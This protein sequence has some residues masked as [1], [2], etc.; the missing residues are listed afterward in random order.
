[1][2]FGVSYKQLH[3]LQGPLASLDVAAH[4]QYQLVRCRLAAAELA[5]S[6]SHATSLRSKAALLRELN[7]LQQ[8]YQTLMIGGDMRLMVGIYPKLIVQ[9]AWD[10]V[11]QDPGPECSSASLHALQ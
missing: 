9:L 3:G 10:D 6:D 4:V 8:E 5:Y 11:M 2:I 7:L 1:M